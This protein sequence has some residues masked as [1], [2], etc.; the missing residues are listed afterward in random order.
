MQVSSL[1]MTLSSPPYSLPTVA[2]SLDDIYLSHTAQKAL[3]ERF[4]ENPL[5]QH[6]GQP[7]THDLALGQSVL[8]ALKSGLQI[9]IPRYDKSAFSGE[10]DRVEEIQWDL[11][12]KDVKVVIFEGW[13]VG[14]RPLPQD[15]MRSLWESAVRRSKEQSDYNG[16]LGFVKWEDIVVINEAL[17]NY[18]T[19]T[20]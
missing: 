17:R 4:S 20:L 14:F 6:R 8:H 18:N 12:P 10:G 19:L 5:L 11:S 1:Q 16:R 15:D 7:S 2:L 3:A 9:R 13:C